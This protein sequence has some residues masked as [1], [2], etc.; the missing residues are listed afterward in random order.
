MEGY[1]PVSYNLFS[2]S[3][4]ILPNALIDQIFP[5]AVKRSYNLPDSFAEHHGGLAYKHI[6][7][8]RC[9]AKDTFQVEIIQ[10]DSDVPLCLNY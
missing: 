9:G 2:F 8:W 3:S 5:E 10:G 4:S 6:H 7:D 1:R